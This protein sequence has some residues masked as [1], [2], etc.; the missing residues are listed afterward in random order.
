MEVEEGTSFHRE[1]KE[2]HP[3]MCSDLSTR[4]MQANRYLPGGWQPN[5]SLITLHCIILQPYQVLIYYIGLLS[6]RLVKN[7]IAFL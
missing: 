7:Q 3:K 1:V 5:I 2:R 6:G 4:G